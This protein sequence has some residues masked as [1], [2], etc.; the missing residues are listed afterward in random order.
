MKHSPAFTFTRDDL[1][2]RVFGG[3]MG[4]ALGDAMGA[5]T[6]QHQIDEILAEHGGLLRELVAPPIDTFSESDIAGLVTDDSSQMF[7]LAQALIE[8]GGDLDEQTWLNTLLHW[9]QTSPMRDHMGP[10]TRPL[11]EALARGE[12][13]N[14]IGTVGRSTRKLTSMGTTNGAAMRVAPA[15]L[16]HPG[17]VESAV[18]LAWVTCQPTHDTQI[19][20]S[21]AGAIAAGVATALLPGADV[22]TVVRSC[23]E[24]A[25]LG[26]QIGS[27][28]GR[29][30]A[31][32]N[33]RR[34]IE[35]A[36]E[37]ALQASSFEEALRNIEATVGNSVMMVE[38]VPA[39][40]GIF[41]AAA[42]SPL[43]CA[44]G[45][46]NIGNDTDTIAAMAGAL[47]GALHGYDALPQQMVTTIREVNQEDIP[48]LA[49][50][51]TEIA[52]HNLQQQ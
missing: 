23:L 48:R 25:R 2:N 37:T 17:D 6:E 22:F 24:G 46:T 3:L 27:Q 39:A 50:G 47:G 30:V 19:A 16:V 9:S 20:A 28:E 36:I 14:H 12:S 18:R 29:K 4:A 11:L 32:P 10:T 8:S 34:R 26:E 49:G 45:G 21:G 41:V 15:G 44:V 51:L 1:H 33:I 13:T 35:L 42:G 43:E 7:A 31:G 38:S 52:W 40:V 5:A